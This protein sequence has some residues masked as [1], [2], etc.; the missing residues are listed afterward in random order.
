M[1]DPLPQLRIDALKSQARAL[2]ESLARDGT[3]IS[4]SQ[5]L[6]RVAHAHGARDWNT[7]SALAQRT[8]GNRRPLVVGDR[9]VG[10][11]LGQPFTGVVHDV[12][13]AAQPGD[14]RV[15][16]HFDDP[17]DVVTFPAFSNWRQR[18]SALIDDHGRSPHR[19]SDG[20]PQMI[21][22]HLAV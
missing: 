4:H 3:T 15:T 6:E 18:V 17:V 5:A 1:T 13:S 14:M 11:Y 7:L 22:G 12:Q 10:R 8:G 20:V 19:T 2:R 16:L 9:V 21:V